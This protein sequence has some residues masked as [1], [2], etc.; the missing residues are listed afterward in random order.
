M[1]S[2]EH[3]FLSNTFEYS[4]SDLSH[5][6]FL[7]N[8]KNMLK[9]IVVRKEDRDFIKFTF[10]AG[11]YLLYLSQDRYIGKPHLFRNGWFIPSEET[12]HPF[13]YFTKGNNT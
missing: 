9:S 5:L 10:F 13:Y 12:D 6:Y 8:Y 2:V 7:P 4:Q 3:I 11:N 1:K